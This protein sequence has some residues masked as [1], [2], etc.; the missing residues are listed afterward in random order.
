MVEAF[1]VL[2]NSRKLRRAHLHETPCTLH[3]GAVLAIGLLAT[4]EDV[5]VTTNADGSI[6]LWNVD[7][8]EELVPYPSLFLYLPLSMSL[9]LPPPPLPPS[10]LSGTNLFMQP[11]DFGN[12]G[13]LAV[14][15]VAWW[16][17]MAE[18]G[19]RVWMAAGVIPNGNEAGQSRS[20][21]VPRAISWS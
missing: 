10:L 12:V 14:Q 21:A 2:C 20:R 13:G 19:H 4:H 17:R 11:P 15:H 7:T 9:S 5:V 18:R 16:G 6:T 3:S 8:G 1:L